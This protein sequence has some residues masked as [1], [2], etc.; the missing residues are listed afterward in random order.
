MNEA[1]KIALQISL[2]EKIKRREQ[3]IEMAAQYIARGEK[4]KS[5]EIPIFDDEIRQLQADLE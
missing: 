1:T 2:N 5:E 3:L 4:I